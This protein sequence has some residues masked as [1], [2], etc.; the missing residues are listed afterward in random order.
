MGSRT[1][2][3]LAL[4]VVLTT[5]AC[6]TIQPDGRATPEIDPT[7]LYRP[8]PGPFPVRVDD[9]VSLPL[10]ADGSP[11]P[12]RVVYPEGAQTAPVVIFSHGMFASNQRYMPMLEHWASH[13]YVVVAPNHLDANNGFQPRKDD[14]V[15]VLA[16]SRATD[17][18]RLM[19]ALPTVEERIP[20]LKGRLA[21]PPYAAAGHSMG[22]YTAMLEAGLALRNPQSGAVTRHAEDRIAAVLM[23]SDPGNMAVMP[24]T[25]W[26]GINVPTF[27]TTGSKDYGTAGKGRRPSPYTAEVLTGAAGNAGA[28]GVERYR[29]LLE[30][31]DHYYGGLVHRDPGGLQPDHEGLAIYESLST[32]FLDAYIRKDEAAHRYLRSVDLPAITKGRATLER[33][34]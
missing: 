33:E 16:S 1:L 29:V 8:G 23:S 10:R 6:V 5:G 22:T 26:R 25:M 12:V 15:E 19:D 27:M 3:L 21:P 28:P 7:A 14:D 17:L 32:A 34:P 20:A 2:G 18:S 9:S 24:S 4:V 31:G 30:G 11:V 13:G